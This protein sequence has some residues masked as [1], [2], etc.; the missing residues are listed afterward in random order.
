MK[1]FLVVFLSLVLVFGLAGIAAA[2]EEGKLL[3]WADELRAKAL[4]E[5][6]ADFEEEYGIPVEIQEL[7]FGDIR[8]QLGIAGP[9]G[10]GPDI[11]VGAHDW[12]GQLVHDGL[13]APIDLEGLKDRFYSVSLQAFT[14][15]ED[16][17]AIPYAIE[18]V[19]LFYNKDIVPEPPKTYEEFVSI[20]KDV[21]DLENEMYGFLLPQ[22]D[23][24][25]T[26]AFMSATGGYVFGYDENGELDPYNIGLNNRGAVKGLELL[27]K[28]SEE[29]LLPYVDYNTMMSLFKN[30]QVGMIVTGPWAFP[31]VRQAG[32]NYGF[33]KLPSIEGKSPKPFVGVQGFMISAFSKNKMLAQAFLTEYVATK[34][35]MM[36]IYELEGRPP[37]FKPAADEVSDNPDIAGVLASAADGMPMPSIPEMASVWQAWT[38][39]I[40]L[41]LTQKQDAQSALDNAVAQIYKALTEGK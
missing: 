39:A 6:K 16:I 2:S 35:T 1:R 10:E 17:Y 18:S 13:I 34:D 38:D 32:I 26:Y 7:A 15:G 11:L 9:T 41:V 22:P 31:E 25:H 8:D 28:L 4:Q 40:E 5:V 23:P 14:W 20:I 36:K 21:T 27:D 37:V 33:T 30:G 24:Y 3:I 12:L 19:G 29:D